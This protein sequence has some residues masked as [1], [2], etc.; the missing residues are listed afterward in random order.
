M[1]WEDRS[2]RRPKIFFQ[3]CFLY[4]YFFPSSF[5][6]S[7]SFGF[8]FGGQRV[9]FKVGS[10]CSQIKK[11]SKMMPPPRQKSS[12]CQLKLILIICTIYLLFLFLYYQKRIN[13]KVTSDL[14]AIDKSLP[15]TLWIYSF[16]HQ[17]FYG[18][19]RDRLLYIY[20]V[21]QFSSIYIQEERR[22]E[23]V[24][25]ARIGNLQCQLD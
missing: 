22:R 9:F 7:S 24:S 23:L 8:S 25:V 2:W 4:I 13:L 1:D 14:D 12:T 19:F 18:S 15:G 3:R 21:F 16:M 20:G 5:F 17:L 11:E 10:F 6:S